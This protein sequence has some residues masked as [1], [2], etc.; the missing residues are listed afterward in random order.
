MDVLPDNTNE[1][2]MHSEKLA[3]AEVDEIRA[4]LMHT[5]K[6]YPIITRSMMQMALTN[7]VGSAAWKAVLR[8]MIDEGTVV[9]DY[10]HRVSPLGQQRSY[11]RLYLA[12]NTELVK[13]AEC[14]EQQ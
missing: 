11:H 8:L 10:I 4:R 9:E 1:V 14:L 13:L 6:L 3:S 2:G 12:K 7:S 5:L